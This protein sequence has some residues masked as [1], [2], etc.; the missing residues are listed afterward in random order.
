MRGGRLAIAVAAAVTAFSVV[1][2][3]LRIVHP[4]ERVRPPVT[5][6]WD[7]VGYD[8]IVLA[9]NIAGF[10]REDPPVHIGSLGF[11]GPDPVMPK[12]PGVLRIACL[13]DSTT[14]GVWRD[15]PFSVATRTSYAAELQKLADGT[16]SRVD[17]V[18]AGVLGYTSAEA[19]VALLARVLPIAPD[20]VV[21]RLGNNDH[22]RSPPRD[23]RIGSDLDYLLLRIL[24]TWLLRLETT[25][26]AFFAYRTYGPQRVV[27]QPKVPVDRFEVNMRRIVETVTTHGGRVVLLDF[28]YRRGP[29]P[30][31]RWPEPSGAKTMDELLAIHGRYQEVVERVARDTGSLFVRTADDFARSAD[32]PFPEWDLSHP[33]EVGIRIIANRLFEAMRDRGWIAHDRVAASEGSSR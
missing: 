31:D 21:L 18:N 32:P 10:D 4:I 27:G 9:A 16:S 29:G 19:L 26:L 23:P 33:N 6:P 1:E 14:F 22:V 25:R 17:V 13:G 12:P 20:V 24:P 30:G 3:G 7:W 8:P 5:P 15:G 2:A 28:P 11:R